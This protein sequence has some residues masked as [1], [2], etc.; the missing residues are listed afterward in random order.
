MSKISTQSLPT[1]NPDWG[2]FGTI[3]H[4]VC[5]ETA[6]PLA[7]RAIAAATGS[8]PDGVRGFL[9]SRDGR[10]FADDVANGLFAG[11]PLDDAIRAAI[12]RWMGWKTDRHYARDYGI[13]RGLPVLT[14]L[15]T[16]YEIEADMVA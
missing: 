1:Q 8:M 9:D 5:P 6:W 3:A 2:F 16:F 4:H 10:H 11:K 15:T 7:S 14:A 12:A 13:P